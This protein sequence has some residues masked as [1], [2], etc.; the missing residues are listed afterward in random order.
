MQVSNYLAEAQRAASILEG[1][2][3]LIPLGDIALFHEELKSAY[4][5]GRESCTSFLEDGV[6]S[7]LVR[8]FLQLITP[9][10]AEIHAEERSFLS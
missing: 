3:R 2:S 7:P 8:G 9:T 5:Y 1:S 10:L 6:Y 4:R